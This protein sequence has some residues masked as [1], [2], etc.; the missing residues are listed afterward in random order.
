MQKKIYWWTIKIIECL[1]L[2]T[3]ALIVAPWKFDV[4]KT[5]LGPLLYQL[6]VLWQKHS[7]V[8]LGC[9]LSNY[10]FSHHWMLLYFISLDSGKTFTRINAEISNTQIR[11]DNGILKSPV[12]PN[13]VCGKL[14]DIRKPCYAMPFYCLASKL[15]VIG[16][17]RAYL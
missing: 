7:I 3:I 14:T 17:W 9:F 8:S 16:M 10:R 2:R 12:N 5:G 15:I 11:K 1:C 13:K 4:V 6:I